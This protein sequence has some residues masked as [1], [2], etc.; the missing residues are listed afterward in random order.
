MVY[1][2]WLPIFP[3]FYETGYID[4]DQIDFCMDMFLEGDADEAELPFDLVKYIA[5]KYDLWPEFRYREY[6]DA[7]AKQCCEW[8]E[9]KLQRIFDDDQ[10]KVEF[11]KVSSPQYY[12]FKNDSIDCKITIDLDKVMEYVKANSEDFKKY[13]EETYTSCD[14]FHS[15]YSNEIGDWLDPENWNLTHQVG[16]V[17]DFVIQDWH[18]GIHE[19]ADESLL[20][21][22]TDWSPTTEYMDGNADLTDILKS[23]FIKDLSKEYMDEWEKSR[24]YLCSHYRAEVLNYSQQNKLDKMAK[25]W[26][27][28]VF[29]GIA[30]ATDLQE[31][32]ESE[33]T[34]ENYL[35][36][37][38]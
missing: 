14:G 33:V 5:C 10:I 8:V 28:W 26:L 23:K 35:R 31:I 11:E 25:E 12:N 4:E 2:T 13:L 38:A 29:G 15:Y 20:W 27:D 36:R 6:E 32:C 16:A 37:I 34:F 19:Y 17:L 1:K 7:A 22:V 24:E 21:Y 9:E 3:G 18:R 30:E